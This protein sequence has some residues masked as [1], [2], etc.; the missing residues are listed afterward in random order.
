MADESGTSSARSRARKATA[1]TTTPR[2]SKSSAPTTTRVRK[3]AAAPALPEATTTGPATTAPSVRA[4]A[5]A[6]ALEAASPSKALEPERSTPT[7]PKPAGRAAALSVQ[8]REHVTVALPLL[9]RV[10]LPHPQDMAFYAGIGGL[11]ALEL[12]EWPAAIALAVGHALLGQKHN[13]VL[14]EFGEALEDA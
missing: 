13:R 8:R 7:Q 11:V 14:E 1:P 6:P 10:Q 9:G 12:L 3:A 5:P 2:A 4:A